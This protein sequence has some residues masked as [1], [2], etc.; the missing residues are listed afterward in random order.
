ML[1]QDLLFCLKSIFYPSPWVVV[2]QCPQMLEGGVGAGCEIFPPSAR[3]RPPWCRE[4]RWGPQHPVLQESLALTLWRFLRPATDSLCFWKISKWHL[5]QKAWTRAGS[6][7]NNLGCFFIN[8]EFSK[9]LWSDPQSIFPPL[10]T[11]C[12]LNTNV[13][14]KNN[15]SIT[16]LPL[17]L[18][19]F[20]HCHAALTH[21]TQQ[22]VGATH[23]A[24][25]REG[26]TLF[27]A[28]SFTAPGHSRDF[29]PP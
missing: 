12:T 23:D 21:S 10:G 13:I 15:I 26:P 11:L 4:R 22:W 1:F 6:C 2:A 25:H 18:F 20:S 7:R 17:T 28:E 8:S 3:R 19:A 14:S 9:P 5:L 24:G 27:P 29:S 16:S